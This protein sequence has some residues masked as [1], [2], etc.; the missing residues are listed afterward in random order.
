M[1]VIVLIISSCKKAECRTNEECLP[2]VCSTSKCDDNLCLYT[3]QKNCCGN[4]VQESTEDGKPGNKCTCPLDYGK[5]EGIAK[6]KFGSREEDAKYVHYFCNTNNECV[7]GVERN[8]VTPQNYLDQINAFFKASSVVR[9]NKPFDV[10]YDN[11]EF[12]ITL[13]DIDKDLI[14]PVRLTKIKLLYNSEFSRTELLIAEKELDQGFEDVGQQVAIDV[15]LNLD[16][17]PQGVEESGSIRYSIDY[18]FTIKKSMGR[19]SDG[20]PLYDEEIDRGTFTSPVKPI[21]FFKSEQN[22]K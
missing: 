4:K 1:I 12:K 2:K 15:P 13:D 11:F 19:S 21:F 7:L 20:T 10:A 6:V 22:G 8:D 17:K 5:C 16:F 14:L 18:S 3:P 9:Y